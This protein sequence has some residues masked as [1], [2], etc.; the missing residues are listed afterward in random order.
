M[1]KVGR[2]A[3]QEIVIKVVHMKRLPII[4]YVIEAFPLAIKDISSMKHIL[5]CTFDKMCMVKQQ[6]I[7]NECRKVF[8]LDNLNHIIKIRPLK[9]IAK[10]LVSNTI[11]CRLISSI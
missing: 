1:G 8:D 4:L 7:I 9:F 11:I 3:C 10:L 5:N 6:E 2:S